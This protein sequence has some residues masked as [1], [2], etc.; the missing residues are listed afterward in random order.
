MERLYD[1]RSMK[2]TEYQKTG[3]DARYKWERFTNTRKA[4]DEI[5]TT[6]NEFATKL[7]ETRKE[8]EEAAEELK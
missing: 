1:T 5:I 2:V 3:T 4:T 6:T 8:T 7:Y